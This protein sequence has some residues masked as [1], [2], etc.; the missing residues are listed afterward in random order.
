MTQAINFKSFCT[1]KSLCDF[2]YSRNQAYEIMNAM[3]NEYISDGYLLISNVNKIPMTY[4]EIW[5]NKR[6]ATSLKQLQ[7]NN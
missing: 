1:V 2:G 5:A 6:L 4:A 7:G 3:K